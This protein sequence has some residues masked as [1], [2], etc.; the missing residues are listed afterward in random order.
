MCFWLRCCSAA[1]FFV[2]YRFFGLHGGSRLGELEAAGRMHC[3]TDWAS[4]LRARGGETHMDQYC[5]RCASAP[6]WHGWQETEWAPLQP[7]SAGK[8]HG[9]VR[10]ASS[11][12]SRI[13]VVLL[14]GE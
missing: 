1:G 14:A 8:A 7:R 6:D 4:L 9:H 10:R 12:T 3:A 13:S 2:V 11:E 5:F